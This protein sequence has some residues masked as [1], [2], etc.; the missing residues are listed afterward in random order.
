MSDYDF[1]HLRREFFEGLKVPSAP[2]WIEVSQIPPTPF[3]PVLVCGPV[4]KHEV[5]Y[6]E[7]MGGKWVVGDRLVDLSVYP[8]WM[9][10]PNPPFFEG[11][12]E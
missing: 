3:E 11:N 9:P 7:P 4:F 5:A 1:Q 6:L 8:H 10:L 2:P 12:Y